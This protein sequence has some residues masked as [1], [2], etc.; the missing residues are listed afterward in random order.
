MSNHKRR[1]GYR[2]YCHLAHTQER[3]FLVNHIVSLVNENPPPVQKKKS[4][5]GRKPVYS[6]AKMYC[7]CII[8]VAFGLTYRDT[9]NIIISLNLP[10]DEPT[11]DHTTISK[12][13]GKISAVWLEQTLARTTQMGLDEI[14]RMESGSA[15]PAAVCQ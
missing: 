2:Q 9:Q 4:R 5:H 12:F 11:P 10:W 8:M 7:I 3:G 13:F 6:K 15:K 14:N 1:D